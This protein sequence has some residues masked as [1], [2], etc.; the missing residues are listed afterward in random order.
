MAANSEGRSHISYSAATTK[1]QTMTKPLLLQGT[2][3]QAIQA[4]AAVEKDVSGKGGEGL[5]Q[6]PPDA[7]KT[8]SSTAE[9]NTSKADLIKEGAKCKPKMAQIP[10]YEVTS[11]W[12]I[13]HIQYMQDHAIICK[14]I[15]LWPL[16]KSLIGWLKN[17]WKP[18]GQCELKLGA[19][20]FFTVIFHNPKDKHRI[21]Q[22]GPYFLHSAGL[23]M[24]NWK[25]NFSPE[26]EDFKIVPVWIRLY[27]LPQEY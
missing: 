14:F 16:E 7:T 18:K 24:C 22:G 23:Y 8:T 6:P 10:R 4:K 2:V 1:K 3:A 13:Q 25:E 27:S 12:V 5:K 15:G 11:T 9:K 21:F 19:K 20:C 26:K 17:P